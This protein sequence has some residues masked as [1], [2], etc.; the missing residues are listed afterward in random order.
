[1]I[2]DPKNRFVIS[3]NALHCTEMRG[4]LLL[5]QSPLIRKKGALFGVH[6]FNVRLCRPVAGHH[7][8]YQR[9]TVATGA[10]GNSQTFDSSLEGSWKNRLC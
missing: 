2:V 7:R 3:E 1:M 4:V 8:F 10:T 6:G 9:T 5:T